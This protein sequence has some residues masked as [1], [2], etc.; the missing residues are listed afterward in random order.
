MTQQP[1]DYILNKRNESAI[2]LR[3]GIV[4]SSLGLSYKFIASN[5]EGASSQQELFECISN[6]LIQGGYVKDSFKQALIERE[7]EHPTGLLMEDCSIAIPH[8]ETE[9][10]N[11]SIISVIKLN[12]DITFQ[13][14]ENKQKS[15][16]P[17]I[18]FVLAL[19]DSSAHLNVLKGVMEL[20]RDN[21]KK[22]LVLKA[23]SAKEIVS[24]I[25]TWN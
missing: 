12:S 17:D 18:V 14:M 23:Q 8:T 7:Q 6:E 22:N 4:M 11:H 16:Y 3:G 20:F 10:I 9:H 13:L 24:L 2:I 25:D 1:I 15:I 21:Q 19:K 5:I